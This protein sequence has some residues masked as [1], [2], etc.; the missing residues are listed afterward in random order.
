MGM[1]LRQLPMFPPLKA[2]SFLSGT[3][4]EVFIADLKNFY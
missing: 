1:R 2:V 4:G 3:E